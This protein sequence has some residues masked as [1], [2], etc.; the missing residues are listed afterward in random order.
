MRVSALFSAASL[1]AGSVFAVSLAACGGAERPRTL[2]DESRDNSIIAERSSSHLAGTQPAGPDLVGTQWAWS[3]AHCTEGPLDL[4]AEGFART[5]RVKS[6][7]EGLL[8]IHDDVFGDE[9]RQTV[10]QH[11]KPGS[12][13]NAVW[14]VQE[15]SLIHI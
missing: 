9:C 6:T 12:D 10:V 13:A 5:T 11:A 2:V 4:A 8:F 14:S 3:E 7:S 1:A 15:L